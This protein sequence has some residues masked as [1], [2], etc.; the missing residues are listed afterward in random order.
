MMA[1]GKQMEEKDEKVDEERKC[2]ELEKEN[3]NKK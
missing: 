2:K 1:K 3:E